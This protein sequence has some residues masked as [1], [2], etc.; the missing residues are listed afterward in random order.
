MADFES[1]FGGDCLLALGVKSGHILQGPVGTRFEHCRERCGPGKAS[2]M[3][4]EDAHIA[5]FHLRLVYLREDILRFDR[6]G[7]NVLL[8]GVIDDFLKASAVG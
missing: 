1:E 5:S 8:V 4:G 3:R 7:D 2:C 6:R